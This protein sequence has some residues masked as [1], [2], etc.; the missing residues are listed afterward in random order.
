MRHFLHVGSLSAGVVL[1]GVCVVAQPLA[2]QGPDELRVAE[3]LPSLK[4]LTDELARA[5]DGKDLPG[6]L[7]ALSKID[8][9]I[10]GLRAK[11]SSSLVTPPLKDAL[12]EAKRKRLLTLEHAASTSPI[13][14]T[15]L[16]GLMAMAAEDAADYAKAKLYAS[17]TLAFAQNS[18][19]VAQQTY[20][21]NHVLGL[22]ALHEG[23]VAGARTYLLASVDH[24]G[25]EELNKFGP[26]LKLAKRLLE[27]GERDVVI[28]FLEVSKRLWPEGRNKL[29]QW[30]AIIRA[31][32]LP[33][34]DQSVLLYGLLP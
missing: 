2:T 7:S 16:L 21:G 30:Q 5:I 27:K 18:R 26:N 1:I 22:L 3:Q 29:G 10:S 8:A 31:G 12:V 6:T 9:G 13:V 17:E 19:Y 32:V 25:W 33:E 20:Y 4:P 23:N 11:A 15:R 28:E 24:A 34:W 14:R